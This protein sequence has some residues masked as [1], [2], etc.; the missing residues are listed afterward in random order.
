MLLPHIG[1]A[2]I[3]FNGVDH[4]NKLA[5]LFRLKAVKSGENCSSSFRGDIKNYT[6]L[7]PGARADNHKFWGQ[8]FDSLFWS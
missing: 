1:K 8:N 5:I 3:L 6:I 7:C 2:A 4:S